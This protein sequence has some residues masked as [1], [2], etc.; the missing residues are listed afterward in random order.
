[1]L[2]LPGSETCMY[3]PSLRQCH[4]FLDPPAM[5]ELQLKTEAAGGRPFK[6]MRVAETT[7]RGPVSTRANPEFTAL[8]A[9]CLDTP[10]QELFLRH[11]LHSGT[12]PP[13]SFSILQ[14]PRDCR[15]LRFLRVPGKGILSRRKQ[16]RLPTPP[17]DQ[18]HS[19]SS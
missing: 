5:P 18:G 10:Q 15:Q 19:G 6:S 14:V 2:K 8:S 13:P 11:P 16:R 1:M 7:R 17:A 3:L 12:L 9:G 4:P